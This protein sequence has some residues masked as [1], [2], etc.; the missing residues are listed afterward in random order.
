MKKIFNILKKLFVFMLIIPVMFI[1]SACGKD[2]NKDNDKQPTGGIEQPGGNDNSGGGSEN[3]PGG[4]GSETPDE[5]GGGESETPDEPEIEV[6]NFS[7]KLNYDLPTYIVDLLPDETKTAV[8]EE[9]Y[10]LPTFVGTEYETYFDGW[11]DSSNVKIEETKVD[12]VKDQIVEVFAKW[13][14]TDMVNYFYTQGLE[15]EFDADE[16]TANISDYNGT[17][18]IVV[19]P[20]AVEFEGEDY[21]VENVKNGAFKDNSIIKEFR[22]STALT[23]I[24][25]NESAFENS[26]LEKFDFSK[27]VLTEKS[28]FKGT[29]ITSVT[30]GAKTTG[31][32]ESLFEGC[33]ELVSADF[34]SASGA[35]FVSLPNKIFY[36]CSKLSNVYLS[37][38]TTTLGASSFEGCSSIENL[39]FVE[40]SSVVDI[41]NRAFA[42][43]ASLDKIS[44][45]SKIVSYGTGIFADTTISEITTSL[46]STSSFTNTYGDLK[47]TLKKVTL[48]GNLITSIP[49][50]YF[51]GYEY[52]ADFVMCDSITSIG[53]D[54]FLA[55]YDLRNI[56]FSTALVG[57]NINISAFA[58][59]YWYYDLRNTLVTDELVL[60]NTLVY[61]KSSIS[62]SYSVPNGVLYIE[63]NVFKN[64]KNITAVNIPSSVEYINPQAFIDSA[65]VSLTINN[66]AN[67]V[68]DYYSIETYTQTLDVVGEI[69]YSVLY[70][71]DDSSN[72]SELIAYASSASAG[73][74]VVD[75]LVD[76]IY[77]YA[78][79]LANAPEYVLVNS[80]ATINFDGDS[81]V[82][83]I[84]NSEDITPNHNVN[85]VDVYT[86]LPE[87]D[88]SQNYN[89]VIEDKA[90]FVEQ[91]VTYSG[92]GFT[93]GLSGLNLVVI[94]VEDAFGESN[95]YYYLV[96]HSQETILM[97]NF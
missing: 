76:V 73:V 21:F 12:G 6:Q 87:Q 63:K 42:G 61:V 13:K 97:L 65:I 33:T 39:N 48:T 83:Y 82:S 92:F 23:E 51:Q 95:S 5:P 78:F 59:T 11:Y 57:D 58:D 60:N 90:Q 17:S 53:N 14:E 47:E 64:K 81:N 7:V 29:K 31:L 32:S 4:E 19:V 46:I 16:K 66:S 86:L 80:F 38:S 96:N 77:D 36:G 93:S 22:T 52:L 55:C 72:K 18:E 43:C 37:L 1:F 49:N 62:G 74:F 2:N 75:D 79:D 26:S 28:A 71:L 20:W 35:A 3:E 88:A 68:G 34:S 94:V 56:T 15:F 50:S 10:T 41:G 89:Y 69:E 91:E 24:S 67:H 9:G 45:P 30:I 70:K 85:L 54:A 84:L 40:N 25:V 27:L 44:I 8:V